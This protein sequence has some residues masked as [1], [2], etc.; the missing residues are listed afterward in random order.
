MSFYGCNRSCVARGPQGP[1]GPPGPTG[2][3]GPSGQSSSAT[4]TF[5]PPLQKSNDNVVSL[6]EDEFVTTADTD[7]IVLGLK[8]FRQIHIGMDPQSY[9]V[10][11]FSVASGDASATTQIPLEAVTWDDYCGGYVEATVV[12]SLTGFAIPAC[13]R[14]TFAI[15][16]TGQPR[17]FSSGSLFPLYPF[18]IYFLYIP[19]IVSGS[20]YL[21][22]SCA[23]LPGTVR[24]A[25]S[26][27]FTRVSYSPF[28]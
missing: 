2:P 9:H 15:D 20:S 18:S 16:A 23:P 12:A 14:V 17:G 28:S 3:P 27:T 24:Y 22:A 13:F 25:T 7:Q 4:L 5:Q 8:S 21:A 11:S 19:T 26:L 6:I 1:H 10:T